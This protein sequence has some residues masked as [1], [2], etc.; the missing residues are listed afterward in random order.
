MPA[1]GQN[2]AALAIWGTGAATVLDPSLI[3]GNLFEGNRTMREDVRNASALWV[4]SASDDTVVIEANR[5]VGNEG[6]HETHDLQTQV[7]T[8]VPATLGLRYTPPSW[9][10]RIAVSSS[11][12][13]DS[14]S[15]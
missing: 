5:F 12:R 3:S 2:G 4:A 7:T 1:G 11:S 13:A 15:R 6:H 8:T 14:L 10:A 9:T